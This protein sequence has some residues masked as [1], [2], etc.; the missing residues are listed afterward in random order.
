MAGVCEGGSEPPCYLK[1]V[2]APGSVVV[3]RRHGTSHDAA[4]SSFYVPSPL[5]PQHTSMVLGLAYELA[6]LNT[7]KSGLH[8]PADTKLDQT[9]R[10]SCHT[11]DQMP[12]QRE[13]SCIARALPTAHFYPRSRWRLSSPT[14]LLHIQT[15]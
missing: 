6:H 10:T 7:R 4:P 13:G 15:A 9:D 8:L 3:M 1:S 2:V 11:A 12:L 14:S 5:Q